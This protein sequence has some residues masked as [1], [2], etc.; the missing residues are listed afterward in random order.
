MMVRSAVAMMAWVLIFP[1]TTT[2][3]I[4][5]MVETASYA[6]GDNVSWNCARDICT[7]STKRTALDKAGLQFEP[8]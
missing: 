1:A 6:M 4:K 2:A 3:G 7:S 8:T 5:S